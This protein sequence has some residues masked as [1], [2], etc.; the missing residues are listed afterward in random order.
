MAFVCY[1][2]PFYISLVYFESLSYYSSTQLIEARKEFVKNYLSEFHRQESP[3]MQRPSH[4]AVTLTKIFIRK[5][6]AIR[7]VLLTQD[8]QYSCSNRLQFPLVSVCPQRA[9]SV[10]KLPDSKTETDVPHR[11]RFHLISH[12]G[13][14]A[15]LQPTRGLVPTQSHI[16]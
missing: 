5:D 14:Y 4:F 9:A 12:V 11:Y 2:N 7:A 6:I 1:K 13:A 8:Q 16:K 3:R 10:S 15:R